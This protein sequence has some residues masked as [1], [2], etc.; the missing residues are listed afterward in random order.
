M[1]GWL[2]SLRRTVTAP[3]RLIW[4]ST[5]FIAPLAPDEAMQR[6]VWAAVGLVLTT[7]LGIVGY[8]LIDG[9]SPFDALYQTTLTLTTVGFQEV[10]PLSRA[11]RAFTIF[12]MLF[13][14]G[15]ALYMITSIATL[16][17]EGE[18]LRDVGERRQRH[19]IDQMSGHTVFV[20]AGRMG[21]R[22]IEEAVAP[23]DLFVVIEQNLDTAVAARERG[24]VVIQDDA[25]QESAL[26]AS[27][28]ESAVE[29]Y[30]LT[31][32]DATNT[33]ITMRAKKLAPALRVTARCSQPGNEDLMR[34][35]GVT[36]VLSPFEV[37]ASQVAAAR[38]SRR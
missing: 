21:A 38:A 20:G 6:T 11:A 28:I 3:I 7:G 37:I 27:G 5:R 24:W 34:S 26:R 33:F 16:V 14:V 30:A 36:E 15:I 8:V 9:L 25:E 10:H 13:G 12:L 4:R 31:G 23:S 19:M 17:L 29:L 18:L 32:D 35:A 2:V 22:I 1:N